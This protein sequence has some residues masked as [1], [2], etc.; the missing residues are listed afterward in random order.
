MVDLLGHQQDVAE[1]VEQNFDELGVLGREQVA[2]GLDDLT[3]DQV[4]HLLGAGARRVVGDGPGGLLLH[5]QL[6]VG[7]H[8][9]EKRN[10]LSLDHRLD[11]DLRAGRDVGERPGGLHLNADLLVREQ[12]V[13]DGQSVGVDDALGLVVGAG[14]D[15]ADAAQRRA[16]D[17]DVALLVQV[18]QLHQPRNSS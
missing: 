13:E 2:D 4:E 12:S 7:K 16:Q 10:E 14:D 11:L 5:A 1:A 3:L 9:H 15:V 17:A 6:A 18:E 8:V